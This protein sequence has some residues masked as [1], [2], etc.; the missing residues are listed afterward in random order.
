[1]SETGRGKSDELCRHFLHLSTDISALIVYRSVLISRHVC[2]TAEAV[3]TS[4][5]RVLVR[6]VLLFILG[7]DQSERESWGRWSGGG[8]YQ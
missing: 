1:M 6:A 7:V 8:L 2:F 4:I 5:S 3:S